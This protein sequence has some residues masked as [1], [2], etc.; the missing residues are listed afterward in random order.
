MYHRR[1]YSR[2]GG[3]SIDR[4]WRFLFRLLIDGKRCRSSGVNIRMACYFLDVGRRPLQRRG[5][6]TKFSGRVGLWLSFWAGWH[7]DHLGRYLIV[8]QSWRFGY[9][10]FFVGVSGFPGCLPD[11][12]M[13]N[14][15]L[16]IVIVF[17]LEPGKHRPLGCRRGKWKL[18]EPRSESD[19]YSH[20]PLHT[21]GVGDVLEDHALSIEE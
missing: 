15:R 3:G 21:V 1:M 7:L 9:S 11:Q 14:Q 10:G 8:L 19:G 12:A 20:V 17:T 5:N 4:P 6:R 16:L 18:P 13:R 2:L